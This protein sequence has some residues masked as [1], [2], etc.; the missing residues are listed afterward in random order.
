MQILNI[1][2]FGKT[3]AEDFGLIPHMLAEGDPRPAKEQLDAG[4]QHGG[5]WRPQQGFTRDPSSGA[6][7][8]P[9][10]PPMKMLG[11][12]PLHDEMVVLYPYGYVCIVQPDESFEIARMD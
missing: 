8:Y 10:D 4:Y 12:I 6:L 3:R 7:K 9:G 11:A 1:F 5:G 2:L